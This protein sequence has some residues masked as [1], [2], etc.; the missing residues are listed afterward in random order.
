MLVINKIDAVDALGRRRLQNRFPDAILISARTGENLDELKHRIAASFSGR[1][2]D[3]RLLVPHADG[4]ELS[5]LYATGAP[6]TAREDAAEG[7][8][9]TARL[10]R[11]MVGRFAAYRV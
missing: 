6:I 2:V 7:V 4:S 9:V 8:L 5:A 10:P 1:Y 11:E 3:V